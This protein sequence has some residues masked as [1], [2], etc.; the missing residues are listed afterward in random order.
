MA[1]ASQPL[2]SD[3]EWVQGG[4]KVLPVVDKY[5]LIPGAHISTADQPQ[6]ERTVASAH[7]AFRRGAPGPFERGAILELSLIHI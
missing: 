6:V 4:G 1:V 2:L 3:G 7:A 5:R